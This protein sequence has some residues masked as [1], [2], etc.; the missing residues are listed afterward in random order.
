MAVANAIPGIGYLSDVQSFYHRWT[1]A[2]G[3]FLYVD[4]TRPPTDQIY[5]LRDLSPGGYF[6]PGV[7][8]LV[9]PEASVT[10]SVSFA[11]R[12]D[13]DRNEASHWV[14]HGEHPSVTVA[15]GYNENAPLGALRFLASGGGA[16]VELRSPIPLRVS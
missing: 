14:A 5:P 6:I 7:Q 2:D 11:F 16:T 3:D 9:T 10:V 8:W 4:L 15:T 1:L 12:S 13:Y